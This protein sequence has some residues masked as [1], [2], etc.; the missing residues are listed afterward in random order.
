MVEGTL[1]EPFALGLLS[2]VNP[3]GVR[4]GFF[5]HGGFADQRDAKSALVRFHR[6]HGAP[7]VNPE[8]LGKL[9]FVNI[10][11]ERFIE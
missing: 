4:H 7:R 10:D 8:E 5:L 3:L 6:F 11:A 2:S 9:L 1:E